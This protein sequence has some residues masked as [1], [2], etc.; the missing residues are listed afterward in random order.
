MVLVCVVPC[1]PL[2]D[3]LLLMAIVGVGGVTVVGGASPL[4]LHAHT[5]A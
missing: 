2:N 4:E 3:A 1:C 5:V